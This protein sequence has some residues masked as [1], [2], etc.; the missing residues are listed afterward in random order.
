MPQC[1]PDQKP[2]ARSTE[3]GLRGWCLKGNQASA[4]LVSPFE[5]C[6]CSPEGA[7]ALGR[8]WGMRPQAKAQAQVSA[9]VSGRTAAPAADR[10]RQATHANR[11]LNWTNLDAIAL[12]RLVNRY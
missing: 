1:R 9:S 6:R 2:Q 12:P 8:R 4:D 10:A 7:G 3:N 5:Y 11:L